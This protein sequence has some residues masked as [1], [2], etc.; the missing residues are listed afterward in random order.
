[1]A[2]VVDCPAPASPPVDMA[3]RTTMSERI[4]WE[5]CPSCGDTAAVGWIRDEPVEFDCVHNCDLTQEQMATL[6]R[7][8]PD[9]TP[10]RGEKLQPPV[11]QCGP[12]VGSQ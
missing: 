2:E 11:E 4:T 3:W 8:P 12:D 1:M 9:G 6:Q 10:E 7:R 5:Q